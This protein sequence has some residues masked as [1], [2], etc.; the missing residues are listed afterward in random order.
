MRYFKN[1]QKQESMQHYF[2]ENNLEQCFLVQERK[3]YILVS[4]VTLIDELSS[5]LY[6]SW[7]LSVIIEQFELFP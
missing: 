7:H 1:T 3:V 4:Q 6:N 5:W 2:R